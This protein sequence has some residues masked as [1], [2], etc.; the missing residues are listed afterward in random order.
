MY[1]RQELQ[2]QKMA[3]PAIWTPM[4]DRHKYQGKYWC[5]IFEMCCVRYMEL[6]SYILQLI[7]QSDPTRGTCSSVSCLKSLLFVINS[8][9]A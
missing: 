3:N 5:I 2:E 7:C 9:H 4:I 1:E 8:Q 6:S